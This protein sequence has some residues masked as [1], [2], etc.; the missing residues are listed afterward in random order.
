MLHEFVSRGWVVV[1]ITT[2][3]RRAFPG[4][5]RSKTSLGRLAGSRRTSRPTAETPIASSWRAGRPEGT[6]PRSCAQRA[7]SRVAARRDVG[8]CRLVGARSALVLWGAGDDRRR[9]AVARDGQGTSP[10]SR[11]PGRAASL[12]GN[13][14]VYLA[15]SP[16]ERIRPTR[17]PSSSC[18]GRTTLWWRSTWPGRSS[19]SF[20]PSPS[21]RRTTWNFPSR[22]TPS[23]LTASPRTSA[24]TRAAIA[25]AESVT[26]APASAREEL[27]ASYQV[28]PTRSRAAWRGEWREVADVVDELGSL[29]V[30]TSDNPFS[31]VLSPDENS[32]GAAIFGQ[33][34][35]HAT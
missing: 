26:R 9:D 14:H 10:T 20:A 32:L 24:T 18:R 13:E 6:S 33:C 29:F 15:L 25:F 27:I 11:K 34:L 35:R 8:R 1:A 30:V 12:P 22:S 5:R 7:R 16:Y 23:I 2:D 4:P 31:E 3:W 17:R 28:P 19:R 21:P